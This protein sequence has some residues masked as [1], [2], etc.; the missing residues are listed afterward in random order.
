MSNEKL[1]EKNLEGA[2]YEQVSVLAA[3]VPRVLNDASV[4]D[5]DDSIRE[6]GLLLTKQQ[7]IDLRRYEAAGLALPHRLADVLAYLNFGVGQD[8]GTGLRAADFLTTFVL[9]RDHAKRWSPLRER[10]MLT[11]T[12][13]KSFGE[14]MEIYGASVEE[15][16]AEVKAAKLIE[17]YG[18][19]S[20]ADLKKVELELGGKFPGLELEPDTIPDLQYYLDQIFKSIDL[21]LASVNAIKND[22]DS[23]DRALRVEVLPAIQ[24]RVALIKRNPYAA[25]IKALDEVIAR[26]AMEIADKNTQ[27]K[28]LVEKSLSSASGLNIFGLGMAIYQGIEAEKIRKERNKLNEAQR[29]DI[30]TLEQKNQT[31]GSLKRVEHNLQNLDFIA[32]EA[33][34]ATRNLVYTWNTIHDYIDGSKKAILNIKDALELRHFMT[35]FR[36]VVRP[37][38]NIQ[39]DANKLIEV[40]RDADAE[41]GVHSIQ[42]LHRIARMSVGVS[43][44]AL[45]TKLLQDCYNGM[46]RSRATAEA[47]FIKLN[48][49]PGVFDKYQR[50]VNDADACTVTLRKSSLGCR[51]ELETKL[52]NLRDLQ[53]EL[54]ET[55][56]DS[57]LSM[58]I[59][60]DL[61]AELKNLL[62]STYRASALIGNSLSNI[63]GHFDRSDTLRYIA[64]L[65]VEQKT[66]QEN[67]ERLSARLAEREKELKVITD[68]I[69]LIEKTAI[70]ELGN[71]VSLSID[72]LSKLGMAPPQ[73]QVVMFAVEQLKKSIGNIAKGIT[74]IHLVN[75]ARALQTQVND[76]F[77]KI[78]PENA[79]IAVA[80]EKIEFIQVIH[81]LDD[82]RHVYA[83]EYAVAE[84][85]FKKFIRFV[86]GNSTGDVEQ[87]CSDFIRELTAFIAFVAVA[88]R[89]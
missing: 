4:G 78:A 35:A 47:L 43:Y 13:L 88:A 84:T 20:L 69:K 24:L 70:E 76:L 25:D 74:F 50:L 77:G 41:Y 48:Y 17:Q 55:V 65:E 51:N 10:I 40:F 53:K 32:V 2:S 34:V 68:A 14:S 79:K 87:R 3:N 89:P 22:L 81:S 12:G 54:K 21:N 46:R 5:A 7:I 62:V 72:Q 16:Y 11:G 23:F 8:G 49:L 30:N 86:E 44:P 15:V 58:D 39:K 29:R 83:A 59:K 9:V 75:E 66:I 85:A 31:V 57:Q 42:T 63:N 38:K 1:W 56:A 60:D 19:K 80:A 61:E 36:H 71:D 67:K 18:I 64:G 82:Q 45:N 52:H 37:W 26:R 27:Y 33:E 28:T 73:A 6:T